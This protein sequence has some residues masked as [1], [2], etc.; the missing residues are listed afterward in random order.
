VTQ[1][2]LDPHRGPQGNVDSVLAA[3]ESVVRGRRDTVEFAVAVMIAGGHLLLEDRPGTGKTTLAKALSLAMGGTFRRIQGTADLLPTDITGASVWN[4]SAR[5]FDFIAGPL[6]ANVVLID[7]LNRIPPRTQSALLEA[8]DER[9]VTVDGVCHD[10]PDPFTIIAT[11]NPYENWGTYPLPEGQLDRFMAKIR[12]GNNHVDVERRVVREQ[13]TGPSVDDLTAVLTGADFLLL[14][15]ESRR[16]H[17]ADSV[18]DYALALVE[19]TRSHPRVHTGASTRAAIALLR[20]AQGL[21]FLG[22][23]TYVRPDEVKTAARPVLEHRLQLHEDAQTDSLGE[24][25]INE[26]LATV[27]VPLA[28]A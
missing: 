11:Q 20:S 23:R 5:T 7:E 24:R 8:M 1:R 10:L 16:V 25:V 27:P 12:L 3:V 21:A 13:L 2:F 17:V 14:Q 19:S 26:A 28:E 4:P 15:E 18:L 22:G 6:F 9:T